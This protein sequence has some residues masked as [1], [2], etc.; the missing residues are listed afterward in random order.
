MRTIFVHTPDYSDLIRHLSCLLFIIFWLSVL[1]WV[2]NSRSV[3][4]SFNF[5]IRLI[6]FGFL[7]GK[8]KPLKKPKSDKKDYDE[9]FHRF[10][11]GICFFFF[12]SGFCNMYGG[13][14]ELSGKKYLMNLRLFF[15][16]L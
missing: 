13:R 2:L 11:L 15:W 6:D 16:L 14:T 5:L 10:L 3:S 4:A 8:A 7:G 12:F 9:V 1:I